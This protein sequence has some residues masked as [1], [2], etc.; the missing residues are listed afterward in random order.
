MIEFTKRIDDA[1]E[2]FCVWLNDV[3]PG[4]RRLAFVGHA[5]AGVGHWRPLP[6]DRRLSPSVLLMHN[7]AGDM[8]YAARAGTGI[9]GPEDKCEFWAYCHMNGQPCVW[10]SGK[11]AIQGVAADQEKVGRASCPAGT[12][13][14]SAW[15]GCCRDPAGR[16]KLIAFLDCCGHGLCYSNVFIRCK[17]WHEAKNWCFFDGQASNIGP[18]GYYCTIAVWVGECS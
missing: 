7:N 8:A 15:Y 3:F 12:I 10:C 11:N 16:L 6:I 13:P 4:D 5:I 14:G 18:R 2:R 1:L 9:A 17:R